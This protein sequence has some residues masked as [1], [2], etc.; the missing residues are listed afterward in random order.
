MRFRVLAY[1]TAAAGLCS[2]V[3][4]I[5]AREFLPDEGCY[6]EIKQCDPAKKAG[7]FRVYRA[8]KS[9]IQVSLTPLSQI[10]SA[11]DG[12]SDETV[13]CLV[14]S[15]WGLARIASVLE[16]R[17]GAVWSGP[18]EALQS[19]L[20]QGARWVEHQEPGNSCKTFR[21]VERAT[22]NELVIVLKQDGCG[23]PGDTELERL[24]WTRGQ[25][26]T[27]MELQGTCISEMVPVSCPDKWWESFVHSAER[28]AGAPSPPDRDASKEGGQ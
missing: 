19:S 5:S 21:V 17:D 8:P 20:F 7:I 14:A 12:P 9:R 27:R 24:R 6:Q 16:E 2:C 18:T 13:R 26:I 22:E 15:T 25:G 4:G 1:V 28:P 10:A 11:A 3:H 23:L